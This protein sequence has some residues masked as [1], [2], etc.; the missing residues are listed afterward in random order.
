MRIVAM[1]PSIQE[2]CLMKR[3][4]DQIISWGAC[5]LGKEGGDI[6]YCEVAV[7]SRGTTSPLLK[8]GSE[9]DGRVFEHGTV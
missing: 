9:H 8:E 1:G 5:H 7:G 2:G 4:G 3:R 6:N